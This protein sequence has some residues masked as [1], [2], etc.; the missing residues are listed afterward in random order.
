M[1]DRPKS[2]APPSILDVRAML[3][4]LLERQSEAIY[5]PKDTVFR[6]GEPADA[7]FYIQKG[8]IRISIVSEH[9][10][11]G[12]I[13]V[14]NAGEFLGEGCL[15]GQHFHTSTAT[16]ET[17]SVVIR[18]RK[19]S[20]IRALHEHPAF[21]AAFTTFLLVRN[22][23]IEADLVDHL[24]NSSERRLARMLLL[25]AN[26]AKDGSTEIAVTPINQDL[27]AARVGTTRSRINFFMNK[28]RKL[29]FVEYDKGHLKV[30]ASLLNVIVQEPVDAPKSRQVL[31]TKA[32]RKARSAT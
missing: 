24:F 23:E 22:S 8:S 1:V 18:I 12:I 10:K 16:A 26:F 11:E 20:M 31:R 9:G 19:E 27:L 32:A 30:H 29:G 3:G 17:Q 28:F 4:L 5:G 15:A 6:Q 25:L 7:V 2:Q 14:L 13:T 21:S